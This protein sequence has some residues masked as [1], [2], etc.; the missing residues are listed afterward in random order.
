MSGK[1]RVAYFYNEEI[2][3]FYYSK[4]HPMKPKRISMTHSLIESFDLSRDLDV[5]R[6]R[7]ATR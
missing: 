5:Y 6:S 7:L 3:K 1:K 4:D 2:G